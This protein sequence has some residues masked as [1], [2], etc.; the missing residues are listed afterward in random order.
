[1]NELEE[2]FTRANVYLGLESYYPNRKIFGLSFLLLFI[3]Y[4]NMIQI[5]H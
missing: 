1:M 2:V 3:Q 5:I 4:L